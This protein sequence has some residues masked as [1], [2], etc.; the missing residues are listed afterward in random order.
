MDPI[1]LATTA[2]DTDSDDDEV[3]FHQ[4]LTPLK[5]GG[6][7]SSDDEAASGVALIDGNDDEEEEVEKEIVVLKT[8]NEISVISIKKINC[9]Y[10][11][12]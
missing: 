7:S 6:D 3:D 1:V 9:F 5:D 10:L 4:N 11:Y 8:K 2:V 12:N